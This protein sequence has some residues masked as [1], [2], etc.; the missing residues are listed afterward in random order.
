MDMEMDMDMDMNMDIAFLS[1]FLSFLFM[2]HGEWKHILLG[3]VNPIHTCIHT[4]IHRPTAAAAKE[5]KG[6]AGAG[7]GAGAGYIICLVF[8]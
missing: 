8:K 2:I 3:Q 5:E 6:E 4:Y 1:F 7:A